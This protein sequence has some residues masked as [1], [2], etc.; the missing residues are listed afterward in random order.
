MTDPTPQTV[1]IEVEQR[2]AD[3]LHALALDQIFSRAA[4]ED[5]AMLRVLESV[6]AVTT[7]L[8]HPIDDPP[9]GWPPEDGAGYD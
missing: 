9:Y 3:W 7:A 1:T 6:R 5:A 8:R 4:R 2:D